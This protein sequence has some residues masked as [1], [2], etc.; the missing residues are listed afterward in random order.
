MFNIYQYQWNLLYKKMIFI[1]RNLLLNFSTLSHIYNVTDAHIKLTLIW[2][3]AAL[4]CATKKPCV[5]T[6]TWPQPLD[7][8]FRNPE[9]SSSFLLNWWI[10][11]KWKA[12]KKKL[13]Y[14]LIWSEDICYSIIYADMFGLQ[15]NLYILYISRCQLTAF[16]TWCLAASVACV[17]RMRRDCSSS[18]CRSAA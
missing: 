14:W 4:S 7:T 3:W 12:K 11:S 15:A 5:L 13:Q 17:C 9:I 18:V 16:S 2:A 8:A 1:C 6:L 10:F